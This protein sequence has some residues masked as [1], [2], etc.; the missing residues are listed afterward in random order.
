MSY[1]N[2]SCCVWIQLIAF[3]DSGVE[4]EVTRLEPSG[5]DVVG[6]VIES[7]AKILSF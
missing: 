5:H 4:V 6:H 3:L 1:G 2:P 7:T